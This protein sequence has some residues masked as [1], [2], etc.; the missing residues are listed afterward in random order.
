[1]NS[2]SSLF[3][4][5]DLSKWLNNIH[6]K[7]D[8]FNWIKEVSSKDV[9]QSIMNRAKALKRFSKK[10]SSFPK[11]KKKSEDA[12]FDLMVTRQVKRHLMQLPTLGKIKLKEKGYIPFDRVKSVTVSREGNRYFVSV[13]VEEEK[14]TREQLEESD[15]TGID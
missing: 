6:S 1:Y 4:G 8:D 14:L 5:Y 10:Q 2:D 7:Q 11:F 3:S 15:G 13:L 9:K 12:S